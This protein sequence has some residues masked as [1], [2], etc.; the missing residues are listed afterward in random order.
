MGEIHTESGQ[1]RG[2][3][4][5]GS[6]L[7]ARPARDNLGCPGP[8]GCRW[9]RGAPAERR[10]LGGSAAAAARAGGHRQPLLPAACSSLWKRP[11]FSPKRLPCGTGSVCSLSPAKAKP[12]PCPQRSAWVS[13]GCS[14]LWLLRL[15]HFHRL[16]PFFPHSF[17]PLPPSLPCARAERPLRCQGCSPKWATAADYCH[18]SSASALLPVLPRSSLLQIAAAPVRRAGGRPGVAS[19]GGTTEPGGV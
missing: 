9:V 16:S 5:R 19:A 18:G 15:Q 8:W 11:I 4:L 7:G 10:V 1:K 14:W 12:Y 2:E 6:E 3:T 17:P 13:Q